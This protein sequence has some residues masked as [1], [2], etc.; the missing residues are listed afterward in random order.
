MLRCFPRSVCSPVIVASVFLISQGSSLFA[1]DW[2]QFR[3]PNCSGVASDAVNLPVSFSP[4]ENN[5]WSTSVGDGI[6]GACI[7]DGRVFV[8]GMIDAHTILLQARDLRVGRQLWE[9]R[10]RVENLPEIH[11]T[12]SHASTTPAADKDHVYFY[13]P[14]LGLMALNSE[15]GAD[16]WNFEVPAPFFVFKWGPGMSPV[17]CGDLVVFC[18]DDDLHP[19]IYA[20]NRTDGS[21]VWKDERSDMAVNYSHPVINEVDGQREIVVAGT[22]MVIGYDPASGRRKWF[23][24]GLLR[25]IKTTPVCNQGVV[26]ISLQSSGIANQWLVAIDQAET[27]NH[28][29]RIDEQETQAFFG[30]HPIPVQFFE[31]TFRR[32]DKDQNGFLEGEELDNAFLFPGNFAGASFQSLG[33]KAADEYVLAVRGGGEGDVTNTHLLWKHA[34][35]HTDHVVSPLLRSDSLFLIKSGG[36]GTQFDL[37]KGEML[38]TPRRFGNAAN[39][40][41]SPVAGAGLIYLAADNGKVTVLKDDP[42]L[43]QLAVNDLGESIVATPAIS[44][45]AIVF[46][47]RTILYCIGHDE[48]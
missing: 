14:S 3:G 9:R 35:R 20:L 42:T 25:N 23:V 6:G 45:S 32:G 46:R 41:A 16:V 7:V 21:L 31:R 24:R 12:N 19:A 38:G 4:T 18:Q 43:E 22:G 39:Y 30:E 13:C 48:R 34:T 28:D 47:T 37:T 26:Y 1:G 17:L 11:E 33:E 36:I 15:T 2:P 8:S 5:R 10:W 29:G 40:F 27:G 44:G